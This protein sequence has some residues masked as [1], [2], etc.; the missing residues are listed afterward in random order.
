MGWVKESV[1]VFGDEKKRESKIMSLR[2]KL[3]RAV[4][5]REEGE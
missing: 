5:G 3:S 2:R 1:G 4:G